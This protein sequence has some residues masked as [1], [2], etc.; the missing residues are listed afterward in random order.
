MLSRAMDVLHRIKQLVRRGDYR[1]TDK[2]LDEMQQD[3]LRESDVIESILDADHI[4]KILKA[5]GIRRE[6]KKELL[7][8]IKN[9]S[10]DGT[11]I[12]TKGVI[13]KQRDFQVFYILVSSKV[14]RRSH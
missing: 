9:R 10:L 13:R 2:A 4:D 7:Y 1:F 3:G 11:P 5:Q 6:P 8:V 12:Y 14:D